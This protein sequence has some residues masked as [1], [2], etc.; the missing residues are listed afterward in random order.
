MATI[1]EGQQDWLQ[2]RGQALQYAN[3]CGYASAAS[4]RHATFFLRL[5]I[6]PAAVLRMAEVL[7]L[8]P[9]KITTTE[10]LVAYTVRAFACDVVVDEVVRS[11][12]EM[13]AC[14]KKQIS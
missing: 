14:T 5:R 10:K 2:L 6:S 11:A 13:G 8:T 7:R 9:M 12:D 3:I 1:R 4:P